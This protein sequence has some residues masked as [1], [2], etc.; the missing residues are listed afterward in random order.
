LHER[1]IEIGSFFVV[2]QCWFVVAV[3]ER[4]VCA[5]QM[6]LSQIFVWHIVHAVTSALY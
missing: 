6:G 4:Y 5:R 3:V 1:R 2:G